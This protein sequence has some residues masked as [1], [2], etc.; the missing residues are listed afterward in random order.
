MRAGRSC[1][2]KGF[3]K[4]MMRPGQYYAILTIMRYSSLVLAILCA[5]KIA[6]FAAKH[7]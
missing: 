2:W 6:V 3:P 7:I 1:E 4:M 5:G